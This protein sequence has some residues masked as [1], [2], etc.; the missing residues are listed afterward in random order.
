MR[1]QRVAVAGLSTTL[2]NV[3]MKDLFFSSRRFC[4]KMFF[5]ITAYIAYKF[6][7]AKQYSSD[8]NYG[9][10]MDTQTQM[11]LIPYLKGQGL[12]NQIWEYR[13]AAIIAR[14]TGRTL[15]LEPFHKFYLQQNGREFIPFEDLFDI[16]FFSKYVKSS[17]GHECA[18]ACNKKLH[19]YIE[20]TDSNTNSKSKKLSSIPEWRP[21]SLGKFQRST[22]FEK[23]PA[24]IRL[25]INPTNDGVAFDSLSSIET[26][27]QQVARGKCVAL[28]GPLL[29]L[30]HEFVLWTKFLRANEAILELKDLIL[31]NIFSSSA[32]LAIHWRLEETKCAGVGV[33]IGYGREAKERNPKFTN[34]KPQKII[35]KS[36]RKANLCFYGVIPRSSPAQIW[37]RLIS[38]EAMIKWIKR[39]MS[40]RGI[41]HV[42]LASDLKDYSL[43][44]WIKSEVPVTT[45]KDIEGILEKHAFSRENDV[46]SILEQEI[47]AEADIFAGTQMSSWTERVIEKRFMSEDRIFKRDKANMQSRPDSSNKSFYFD[48]E[49][50]SCELYGN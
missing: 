5:L 11:L 44:N 29:E 45:K 48:V 15:C 8:K 37:F 39:V 40:T 21:G 16:N 1:L 3:L 18:K 10:G 9:K 14:A 23:V 6:I 42:Y 43:L 41:K 4:R 36:D 25:N 31:S 30:D 22:G 33:G 17:I 24:P 26:E 38:K 2:S 35:R 13:T 19:T 49:V 12:N 47:C 7:V 20:L 32:Y 46:V 27:F 28:S 50:C 34:N